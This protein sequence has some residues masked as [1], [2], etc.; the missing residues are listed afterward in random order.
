MRSSGCIFLR[1]FDFV[2]R[3]CVRV[4]RVAQSFHSPLL[5]FRPFVRT[6]SCYRYRYLFLDNLVR[7][8]ISLFFEASPKHLK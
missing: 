8:C 1:F 5:N 2:S 7:F 4:I 6:F 3:V